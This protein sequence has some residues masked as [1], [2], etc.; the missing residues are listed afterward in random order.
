MAHPI[1]FWGCTMT[2]H[3]NSGCP[4]ENRQRPKKQTRNHPKDTT[5]PP[6]LN[7]RSSDPARKTYA[8]TQRLCVQAGTQFG[9]F[10]T[11]IESQGPFQASGQAPYPKQVTKSRQDDFR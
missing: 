4:K 5:K 2:H 3:G 1:F 6:C 9:K 11:P 7:K 10:S 8:D